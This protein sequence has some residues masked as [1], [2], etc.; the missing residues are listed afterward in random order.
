M[1]SCKRPSPPPARSPW[2]PGTSPS[3][4]LRQVLQASVEEGKMPVHSIPVDQVPQDDLLWNVYNKEVERYKEVDNG[5]AR[6]GRYPRVN[7]QHLELMLENVFQNVRSDET[8]TA[9]KS[10]VRMYITRKFFSYNLLS[11]N[12]VFQFKPTDLRALE[13]ALTGDQPQQKQLDLT[14]KV[15]QEEPMGVN[16]V[17]VLPGRRWGTAGDRMLIVGAHYDT[18][19]HSPG[20]DDNGSGVA[21]MLEA[22]RALSENGCRPEFSLL[23]VAFDLEEVGGAGSMA[24]IHQFLNA[25]ILE[26]AG[27]PDAQGAFILDTI[28]NYNATRGVQTVPAPWVTQMLDTIQR[29]DENDARGDFLAAIYRRHVDKHLAD[30]YIYHYQRLGQLDRFRVERFD[31]DLPAERP[32]DDVLFNHMDVMRSDHSRFWYVSRGTN[33]TAAPSTIPAV[34]LTDTG[35]FRGVMARCYHAECDSARVMH[36]ANADNLPFLTHSTQALVNTLVD[37]GGARCSGRPLVAPPPPLPS[38]SARRS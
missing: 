7:S 24:F 31:V 28:M 12:H 15:E 20:F 8:D 6:G 22:A 35:P 23:F 17:G 21:A 14:V 38:V 29:L 26:P 36:H 25:K 5:L 37:L 2:T 16:V 9:L 4:V 1:C 10:S 33:Q 19:P 13:L 3:D 27:W 30:A 18:V 32:S 11:L 34:L